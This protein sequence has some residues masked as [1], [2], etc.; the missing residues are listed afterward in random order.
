MDEWFWMDGIDL[1]SGRWLENDGVNSNWIES[2]V[3]HTRR[4][5]NDTAMN[6]ETFPNHP[7]NDYPSCPIVN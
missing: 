4:V 6:F 7:S 3:F 1:Y 2:N 5:E